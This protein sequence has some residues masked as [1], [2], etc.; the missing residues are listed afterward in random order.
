MPASFSKKVLYFST[1]LSLKRQVGTGAK[2]GRCIDFVEKL[3]FYAHTEEIV[4]ETTIK[5][6]S[7][8]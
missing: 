2:V 8:Y 1:A 6:K 7:F 4:S 5:I 3:T